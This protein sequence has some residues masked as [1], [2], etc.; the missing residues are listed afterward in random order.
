MSLAAASRRSRSL[1]VYIAVCFAPL[2][3]TLHSRWPSWAGCSFIPSVAACCP[4]LPG[5]LVLPRLCRLPSLPPR[6]ASGFVPGLVALV[7]SRPSSLKRRQS[8]P[9]FV[10]VGPQ[11]RR[12][13]RLCCACRRV[14]FVFFRSF[15]VALPCVRPRAPSSFLS[16]CAPGLHPFL[17]HA[18]CAV[19]APAFRQRP[20][21]S[22]RFLS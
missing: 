18:C 10:A 3:C 11:L 17:L 9:A 8:R 7:S 13:A 4:V 6:F 20:V 14:A 22:R 5:R 16:W 21:L 15:A 12:A 2:S 1:C 19:R